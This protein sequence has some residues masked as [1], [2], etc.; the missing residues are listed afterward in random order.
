VQIKFTRANREDYQQVREKQ[1]SHVGY[2]WLACAKINLYQV[3]FL[4]FASE[5]AHIVL[6]N[7]TREKKNKLFVISSFSINLLGYQKDNNAAAYS[8]DI[9]IF[10]AVI[11][12]HPQ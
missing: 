6:A 10:Y 3:L 2:G 7:S 11:H 12:L 5:E 8:V 9:Y 4:S 1:L